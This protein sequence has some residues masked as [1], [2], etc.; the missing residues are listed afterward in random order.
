MHGTL[1]IARHHESAWNKLG[2]WTGSRDIGLTPYGVE[3]S[4]E[5]GE[6]LK[7]APID[8]AY[9]STLCRAKETL[10]E[11]LKAMGVSVP[12]TANAALNERD[13]GDYTGKNKWEMKELI[14][15]VAFNT[16]RRAWDCPVPNGE[17]LKMV[18]ER[19]VPYYLSDI[20]PQLRAGKN[21]LIVSH[22]NTIRAL[23]KYIERISDEGVA[24]V[25]MLFGSI[26]IYHIDEHGCMAHKE[27]LKT[28][29]D[30]PA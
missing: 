5:M 15:E 29:S 14:G 7:G 21:I 10:D 16:L 1:Y 24:D 4:Y 30:V 13:Y 9:V 28:L 12:I 25:E 3:K 19:A 11:M 26:V 20:V 27:T 23:M 8:S 18:Y 17:T 2:L 6:L 22:G